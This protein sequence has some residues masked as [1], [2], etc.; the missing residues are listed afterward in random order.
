M[1]KKTHFLK[2]VI[3]IFP[4]LY[5]LA[6]CTATEERIPDAD[7]LTDSVPYVSETAPEAPVSYVTEAYVSET[8]PADYEY[9]TLPPISKA[10]APVPA[11]ASLPE[12]SVSE[13][14][15]EVTAVSETVPD[16]TSAPAVTS[17]EITAVFVPGPL[18]EKETQTSAAA[19]E[20]TK[21][22]IT[23]VTIPKI[24]ETERTEAAAQDGSYYPQSGYYPLNFD[25]QK[26]VWISYLEYERIMRNADERE[27]TN[28]LNA[29]FDNIS[30]LG[31]NTVYFQVRA[32]GDAYYD[33]ELF[34]KGD[35]LTGD[36]DPLEIA[37]R[38]AH[39]RGLSIHAW[40]NPM[41]LMTDPQMAEIPVSYKIG[42]WYNDPVKNGT[43][44]VN[45]S[46]RWYLNPAYGEVTSLICSGVS[47]IVAGY[48][49]DGVQIDD[50]FYPTTDPSFDL[51]AYRASGTELEL[52]DW[53]RD[54]IT[55]MVKR[56][57]SAVH[58]A[59]PK[60]VFGISPQ[61]SL[62]NNYSQLYA[63]IYTWCSQ[64][65]CCDY[66]CPQIYFGF[67]N[68]ILPFAETVGAWYGLVTSPDV[69]LV[70]GLAAYKSGTE[71]NYAGSGR[72]EWL[73]STDILAR[74]RAFTDAYN[75]G[76]AFFRYDSIFLPDP[77]VSAY[78]TAERENLKNGG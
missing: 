13:T 70:I 20:Q 43:Y 30:S 6:G 47:E 62:D 37:V 35:R 25:R 31:C 17:A 66:I 69:D 54:T 15:A 16:E 23:V 19:E 26:A 55:K 10:E 29:C 78:V 64:S 42:E 41:R 9:E 21:P 52:D 67:E 14:S 72:N 7:R 63:D 60:A 74:Q 27:F 5:L 12:A 46:G 56:M 3:N 1:C 59:N 11:E 61:G 58:S 68:E 76:Y 44:M 28:S 18:P 77:S 49:V 22:R 48:D 39:D 24:P 33:S 57:Y 36:Y 40:V 71:D 73:S 8:D 65:G 38:S 75:A 32:Y 34:P 45:S 4:A 2:I 50:Y 53:R 51:A